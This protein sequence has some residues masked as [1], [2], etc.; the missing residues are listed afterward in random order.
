[1]KNIAILG[2]TGSIGTQSLDIIADY[3]DEFKVK[4]LVVSRILSLSENRQKSINL[5]TLL[6]S[7]MKPMKHS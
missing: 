2:S 3:P 1:M 7:Q 6:Y 5:S 4:A